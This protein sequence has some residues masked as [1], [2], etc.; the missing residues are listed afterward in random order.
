[1]RAVLWEVKR[2]RA[3]ELYVN[4][5]QRI[6]DTLSGAQGD[7]LQAIRSERTGEEDF[8][9]SNSR[10]TI[11]QTCCVDRLNPRPLADLH[12]IETPNFVTLAFLLP[13]VRIGCDLYSRKWA[14]ENRTILV[15]LEN[16]V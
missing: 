4:Q 10:W 2:F 7:V 11:Q 14:S 9:I 8:R 5:L 13:N 15:K 6:L 12:D 16:T 1:M 3:L